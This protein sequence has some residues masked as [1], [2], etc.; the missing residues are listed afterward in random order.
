MKKKVTRVGQKNR[1]SFN[2]FFTCLDLTFV[3]LLQTC[4]MTERIVQAEHLEPNGPEIGKKCDR[5]SGIGFQ[6]ESTKK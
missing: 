5:I 2:L 4:F 1:F 3:F 6:D